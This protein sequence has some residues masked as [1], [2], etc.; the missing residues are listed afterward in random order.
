MGT[1]TH[2]TVFG[3]AGK[4]IGDGTREDVAGL[5]RTLIISSTLD[6]YLMGTA[7]LPCAKNQ[8]P[9][10]SHIALMPKVSF[11][12]DCPMVE[13]PI[14]EGFIRRPRGLSV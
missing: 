8:I 4:F 9:S 2:G 10:R 3:A 12:Q 13:A 11:H 7:Y 14:Q 1:G 5:A 6:L